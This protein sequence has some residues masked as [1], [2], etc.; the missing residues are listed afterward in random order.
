VHFLDAASIVSIWSSNAL[1]DRSTLFK[2]KDHILHALHLL[3][4]HLVRVAMYG[5]HKHFQIFQSWCCNFC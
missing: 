1:S 3:C 5:C 4:R 2:R